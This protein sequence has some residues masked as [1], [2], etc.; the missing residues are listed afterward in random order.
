MLRK[1]D[2]GRGK[3]GLMMER[4]GVEKL[5]QVSALLPALQQPTISNLADEEVGGRE[6]DRRRNG[7]P[8][9]PSAIEIRRQP[10]VLSS[11]P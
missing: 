11:I 10:A 5:W 1:R 8:Q 4:K 3:V 6:H 9:D 2:G 7:G